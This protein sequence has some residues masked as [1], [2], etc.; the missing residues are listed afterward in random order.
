MPTE[1]NIFLKLDTDSSPLRL[2]A[3]AASDMVNVRVTE[4]ACYNVKGTTLRLPAPVVGLTNFTCQG[5][6]EDKPGNSLIFWLSGGTT[7][8]IYRYYP[9]TDTSE[10][11]L[12]WTGFNDLP[13][14]G[15]AMVDNILTWTNGT[16]EIRQINVTRK[17][18]YDG[19][20]AND[21]YFAN[22]LKRPP[23]L[24]LSVVALSGY[25]VT[26]I[27]QFSYRY[28]YVDNEKSVFAPFTKAFPYTSVSISVSTTEQ[29]PGTATAVEFGY[30]RNGSKEVYIFRRDTPPAAAASF[31]FENPTVLEVVN[32]ADATRLFDAVPLKADTLTIARNRVFVGAYTEGYNYF[33][34]LS[35]ALTPTT[36]AAGSVTAGSHVW[37]ANSEYQFGV[38]P[39]DWAHRTFG[40]IT[41]PEWVLK[42]GDFFT[43]GF[44]GVVTN[45][46]AV[47]S[48]TLPS[49]VK[50]YQ[51]V[52]TRNLTADYFI[53]SYGYLVHFLGIYE[54]QEVYGQLFPAAFPPQRTFIEISGLTKRDIGYTYEKGDLVNIRFYDFTTSAY[55]SFNGVVVLGMQG[56][57]L[58]IAPPVNLFSYYNTPQN[59][60]EG[61][62]FEI[63]RPH[64]RVEHEVFYAVGHHHRRPDGQV[65]GEALPI[66]FNVRGD[67]YH[68]GNTQFND[69]RYREYKLWDGSNTQAYSYTIQPT[70][71][72]IY[73]FIQGMNPS[74]KYYSEWTDDTSKAYLH[75]PG[76]MQVYKKNSE[77][78]SNK[79]L[80]GTRLNGL[81]TFEALNEK[82]LPL[83]NGAIR[84]LVL[85]SNT[86]SEGSVLL[87]IM[88]HET[89]TQYLGETQW[90][91][92]QGQTTTAISNSVIGS[93]TTLRGGYG[94]RNPESVVQEGGRVFWWDVTKGEPVRYAADGLTPLATVSGMR[95][96]FREL[97]Q[98]Q[99]ALSKQPANNPAA[100]NYQVTGGYD[101]LNQ[102]YL[103]SFPLVVDYLAGAGPIMGGFTIAYNERLKAFT[104]RYNFTPEVFA[105]HHTRMF[106]IKQ[107]AI[108]EHHVNPVCNN[109]YGE[110]FSSA[111]RFI[112]NQEPHLVKVWTAVAIEG[113]TV[114]VPKELKN[115][116]GQRSEMLA[117]WFQL[118]E[119]VFYG[120]FRRNNSGKT[121]DAAVIALQNGA[122]LR[123]NYLDILLE[124][125]STQPTRLDAVNV[126]YIA[127]GGHTLIQ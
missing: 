76:A 25:S 2:P 111:I 4:T 45:L 59:A 86:Q 126:M 74:D 38:V 75:L 37:K 93:T 21:P 92:T 5:V 106:S 31:T 33:D 19:I 52:R 32:E 27:Y 50:Y 29:I 48:G 44:N 53:Q 54:G 102:E 58:E 46:Q 3:G 95:T 114:W 82:D 39:M 64:Q 125:D 40:V 118:K 103:M 8:R 13:V 47:L 104:S 81:N 115:E 70:Q 88:Q 97:A 89:E 79:Y 14:K 108:W 7:R 77:R 122:S 24:L 57:M 62:I 91:D 65:P 87:A 6:Y 61:L 22:L 100:Q 68:K 26:D 56:S 18:L 60:Q 109:F 1:K 124:N 117:A 43:N 127:S 112:S 84:K 11:V 90:R 71:P 42:T 72:P 105:R 80:S 78:F 116:M 123:S 63:Y 9:D 98:S 12:E 119:G 83:E 67:A 16:D 49:W 35:L 85:A 94:T 36:V 30:R 110:Q 120:A 113:Q 20:K 34:T 101:P 55:R 41:K 96:F 17:S 28:V 66:T 10:L 15:S 99:R 73:P 121:G 107:G 69:G 23:G 51:L